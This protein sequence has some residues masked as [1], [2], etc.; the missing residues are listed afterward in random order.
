MEL[1]PGRLCLGKKAEIMVNPPFRRPDDPSPATARE[2]I[3]IFEEVETAQSSDP[4]SN[5][6]KNVR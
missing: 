1:I 4:S 3:N 2:T 5:S 6:K